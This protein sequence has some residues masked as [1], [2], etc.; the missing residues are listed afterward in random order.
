M[1]G[2]AP[3]RSTELHCGSEGSALGTEWERPAPNLRWD[4][5]VEREATIEGDADDGG[6][7]SSWELADGMCDEDDFHHGHMDGGMEDLIET[8]PAL[9]AVLSLAPEP[10]DAGSDGVVLVDTLCAYGYSA[11]Q[12]SSA[13]AAVAHIREETLRLNAALD[14][15]LTGS[16]VQ[17][18]SF[19]GQEGGAAPTAPEDALHGPRVAAPRPKSGGQYTDEVSARRRP[20]IPAQEEEGSSCCPIEL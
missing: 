7:E 10:P 2:V 20:I 9:S 13:L 18:G 11:Q 1:D 5:I 17:G 12:A 6:F 16:A 14:L 3:S 8:A 15:L 4:L 19:S